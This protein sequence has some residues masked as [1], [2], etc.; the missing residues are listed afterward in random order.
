MIYNVNWLPLIIG[1]CSLNMMAMLAKGLAGLCL[2]L[3]L[4]FVASTAAAQTD[5]TEPLPIEPEPAEQTAPANPNAPVLVKEPTTKADDLPEAKV[6]ESQLTLDFAAFAEYTF[7]DTLDHYG[8]KYH[9]KINCPKIDMTKRMSECSGKADITTQVDGFLA[10][11]G[12]I[13]CKLQTIPGEAPFDVNIVRTP[14]DLC[15][16]KVSLSKAIME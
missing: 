5:L 8:I 6:K 13:E 9:L 12:N 3:C 15:K 1:A 11:G 14:D 10:K 4:E 2:V 7:Y 16:V